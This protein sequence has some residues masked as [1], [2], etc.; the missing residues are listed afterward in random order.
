MFIV[1]KKFINVLNFSVF[2]IKKKL[3]FRLKKFEKKINL[4]CSFL[5]NIKNIFVFI[6]E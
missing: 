3:K 5:I 1:F 2:F 6:L 4:I